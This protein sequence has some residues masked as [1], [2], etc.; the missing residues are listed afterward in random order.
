[1]IYTFIPRPV[2]IK[3]IIREDLT[4]YVP[5][6]IYWA[7]TQKSGLLSSSFESFSDLITQRTDIEQE[8]YEQE[9]EKKEKYLVQ[10]RKCHLQGWKN[11]L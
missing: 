5:H 7:N 1:M 9:E 3:T 4:Q 8:E 11:Y 10:K 6:R 2:S